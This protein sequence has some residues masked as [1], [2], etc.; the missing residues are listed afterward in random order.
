MA[1]EMIGSPNI[2]SWMIAGLALAWALTGWSGNHDDKSLFRVVRIVAF[3]AAFVVTFIVIFDSVSVIDRFIIESNMMARMIV[4]LPTALMVGLG[5]GPAFSV[6]FGV[7]EF[8]VGSKI[9]RIVAFGMIFGAVIGMP[10]GAV[11]TMGGGWV[12]AL[13]GIVAAL[14]TTYTASISAYPLFGAGNLP[15]LVEESLKTGQPWI[16]RIAF[17]GALLVYLLFSVTPLSW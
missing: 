1:A 7:T 17:F 8:I 14:F 11:V 2:Y 15:N 13:I 12:G 10:F 3:S 6:A 16:G 4:G 9:P 5:L